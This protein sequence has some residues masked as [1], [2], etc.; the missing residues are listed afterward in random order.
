M[1]T[2]TYK[3][4]TKDGY[5]V[6]GI[7]DANSPSAVA[8]QLDSTGYLPISI[9]EKK[10][11]SFDDLSSK[12]E[13]VR[14]EDLIFFTRQL[15]TIIKSGIPLLA[16]LKAI[17]QQTEN[18]KLKNVISAIVTDVD[19]GN[20]LSGALSRHPKVFSEL[21]INMI[22]AGE[23]GGTLNVTLE[24]LIS[25]LEFNRKTTA[26]LKAAMRYPVFVVVAL[27]VA[28]GVLVAFVIPQF[29]MIFERSTVE[30]P[31]PT[32]IMI[33]LNS[34]VQ[35]YWYYLLFGTVFLA[36]AFFLYIRQ[37]SGRLNWDHLKLKTPVLGPI[38]LKIYMSRFCNML[39][40]LSR[41]GITI[42]TALELVSR[43]VGN[44][45][46]ALKI[47]EI[48]EKVKSGRGIT[49]PLKESEVF[50]PLV[51]QMIF[52]GEETG[53]LDDMLW[54]VSDYYEKEV[55]YSV[56]RVSSYI[57]PILTVGLGLMVL[58]LALAIFL[59]WWDMIKAFKS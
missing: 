39:E 37:E 16:G 22:D 11:F 36:V 32:R 31:M 58:F 18:K 29:A 3:A 2:F 24:R 41:S 28:F 49:N 46:I 38:F 6:S 19:Q 43:S 48:A 27:C 40:T 1:P 33:L 14:A 21:Y 7:M 4:Q 23:I 8:T 54:E 13:R 59:P 30:L 25:T 56:S 53:T 52:T 12:F 20:T 50:P 26:N 5:P 51:V 47:R 35:N 45:Y 57:E 9:T 55:D 44:E 10:T 34:V 15:L 42:V 17:G